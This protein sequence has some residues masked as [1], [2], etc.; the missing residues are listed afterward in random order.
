MM[1]SEVEHV[2]VMKSL[3][4]TRNAHPARSGLMSVAGESD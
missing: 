1:Y 3:R 4:R 2:V